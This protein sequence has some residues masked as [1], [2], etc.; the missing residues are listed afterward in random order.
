MSES[1]D[2]LIAVS[3]REALQRRRRQ[4]QVPKTAPKK[5]RSQPQAMA[6]SEAMVISRLNN[7]I[8]PPSIPTEGRRTRSRV[9]VPP[10][11]KP[12]P[13]RGKLPP[14][15]SGAVK[16]KTVRVPK[17]GMAK[18][19]RRPSRKTRLKPMA[20]TMLYALRLLI[21]GVGMGA[22][23]GTLL[24]I[25]DPANRIVTTPTAPNSN[26]GQSQTSSN[27][28]PAGGGLYLSQEITPLK[29]AVQNLAAANPNLT[30]GVFL[31]DL[32]NGGYVDISSDNSFPAASTIKIP[33][34]IAFFQD[35]DAGKIRLDEM[36]TMQ[37]EAIASGSGNL[38]YKPVGTQYPALEVATKMITISDNT[39]TNMLISR[40]GGKDALNE[41]FRTWGL[42]NTA[43]RNMLPDLQGTNTTSPK[44]LGNLM[45]MVN[46]GNFLSMRSRDL[47][48][49][50]MRR[51]ERDSLL[52]SG[53]GEGARA[54]HKTGDIGT[55]LA[56]AGLIDIPTGKRYIAAVMVK[57]PQNDPRA[58]KLISAISRAAYQHFSKVAVTPSTPVNQVNN[59]PATNPV[60]TYPSPIQQPLQQP[61]QPLMQP[62]M[63]PPMQPMIQPPPMNP[64]VTDG[65][66][67]TVPMGTYPAPGVN[68]QYYPPQ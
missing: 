52:P 24:S 67:N 33:I 4:R 23:V 61:I 25:L 48:L 28:N 1:S 57:R 9:V 38:Q 30:P 35:V 22:I 37:K 63:Q 2:K 7:H 3:R 59:I 54:Y 5:A 42:A 36:L 15:K 21:V 44:E 20:R 45:A 18:I 62:P 66:I 8:S 46:Q 40:L 68:P 65:T 32:D 34:L 13:T 39:A 47:M 17:P 64:V 53:L 12:I 55:M 10:M 58:E 29:N 31:V 11:V 50:I 6:T 60:S 56:D 41:R 43:V 51:T 19:D 27:P 26:V 49:D 16:V 14:T